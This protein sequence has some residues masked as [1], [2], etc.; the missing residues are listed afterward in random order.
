MAFELDKRQVKLGVSGSLIVFGLVLLSLKPHLPAAILYNFASIDD[1]QIFFN[2]IVKRA[3]VSDPFLV[4]EIKKK[5]PNHET[6][7]L[8]QDLDTTALLMLQEGKI[9]FEEYGGGGGRDVLSGS[10]SMAKSVVAML[11]G[12][13]LQEGRIKSIEEPIAHYLPEW[14]ERDEGRIRIRDLLTMTAGLDWNESY[15]NPFS[16]TTEA[17]Y[18]SNLLATVFKQRRI[19]EPGAV[20][21]YQSGTTQLLGTV[22]SRVTNQTLSEFASQKLW[23]RIGTERDAIWSLDHDDGMEKAYCCFNATAR[24]FARIGELVLNQ[25]RWRG[26]NVLDPGYVSEMVKP[27]RILNHDGVGVDYYGYQWWILQTPKGEVPYARGILGQY[28]V[29]LPQ[30]RRVIV[31][32]GRKTGERVDHHPVELRA[33]VEWGLSES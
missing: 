14:A 2:R 28:V 22:L 23:S 24:D 18:G 12:I 20:F 32:L 6:R 9:A 21:S 25:G 19:Q 4:S 1:H 27:H 10:F 8:L 7:A 5:P 26:A 16:I 15:I 3:P 31:R 17:Y 11:V 29:V 33:L 30:T 13:A